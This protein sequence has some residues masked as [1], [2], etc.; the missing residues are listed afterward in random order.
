MPVPSPQSLLHWRYWDLFV[1]IWYDAEF[2]L[3]LTAFGRHWGLEPRRAD[4]V[5]WYLLEKKWVAPANLRAPARARYEDLARVHAPAYLEQL[6]SRE[7]LARIFG[8]DPSDVPVD[9]VMRSERLGVGA[10]LAAAR[11]SLARRGPAVNLFGGFHHAGPNWGS[12]LCAL[13]DMAV[14]VAA[15]RHEGFT[16]QVVILDLDAHPPDGTAACLAG[17]ARIW[18]GSLSGGVSTPIAG[19]DETVLP[20]RCDDATYLAALEG[21]LGRM[22]APDLAMIVAGGDILAGD[23]LGGLGLSLDGARQRD[24]RVMRALHQVPSV[25]LPG[26]G[27]HPTSWQV[28]AGTV[29]GLVRHT[30][31][32]IAAGEDPMAVRFARLARHLR[33]RHDVPGGFDLT[34]ADV[35]SELGVVSGAPRLLLGR[36]SAE[37]V[38]YALYRFNLLP[39]LERRGYGQFRVAIG[40]ATSG[41]DRICVYG[42][43]RGQEHLL[44]EA[45]MERRVV[46]GVPALYLHWLTLRDP[47][48]RFSGTRPRLPGQEHP[49]LGLARETAELLTLM[50][51]RL[52][53]GGV[54]FAPAH[55]HTAYVAADRFRFLQPRRQG[56]FEA[57]MRDFAGVNLAE[58][59][60]AMAAGSVRLNAEPYA[61]EPEDMV[62]WP[63]ESADDRALADA[64]RDRS[65][66][67][68][69][70]PG[71]GAQ[72][73]FVS[74]P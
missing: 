49:G 10:T 28:L 37:A 44:A 31:Q 18:I 17:D 56:R 15:L 40:Q 34:L 55:Y 27:Y 14:S 54:A 51:Q 1:P 74:R 26:G 68:I 38:E 12:G 71:G 16:G 5:V 60:I 69:L 4:L 2:R 62:S 64:E 73:A 47:Q 33:R 42:Q 32:G 66:F 57:M 41:G 9:E 58:V 25:W 65:Q 13:N 52:D 70:R 20:A 19:V 45:V 6:T 3:P 24:L 46:G 21:L 22:P 63:F 72:E 30:R 29:L 7:T 23:H 61:W 43:A 59:S 50:A 35:E 53:L 36:Y 11:E 48:A 39:F 8:V 67:T